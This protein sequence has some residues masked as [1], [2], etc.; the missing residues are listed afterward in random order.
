MTATGSAAATPATAN[1]TPPPPFTGGDAVDREALLAAPL[2][3]RTPHARLARPLTDLRGVG[4][5]LAAS[6]A[7]IGLATLGDLIEHY[8]HD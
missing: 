5:K 1:A 3:P 8:P 4:A 6:A 2:A 7:R